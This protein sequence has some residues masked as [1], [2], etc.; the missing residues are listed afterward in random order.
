MD[1]FKLVGTASGGASVPPCRT[2]A[3]GAGDAV[4]S[5]P[6]DY[7]RSRTSWLVSRNGGEVKL[8]QN[9]HNSSSTPSLCLGGVG[10]TSEKT[11]V[12]V[13][14]GSPTALVFRVTTG[15]ISPQ[16]DNTTCLTAVQ[17]TWSDAAAVK[18]ALS[19]CAA[20]PSETQ[21][22]QYNP[23]TRALRPK[24]SSCIAT[25]FGE[26]TRAQYRDCCIALC[27]TA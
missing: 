13:R 16:D 3:L 17:R 24:A 7:P 5:T 4:V 1:N 25:S 6:C 20:I 23:S 15:Q 2:S 19:V 21:Q 26:S 12:L 10:S 18:M 14:C 11:V 27:P 9:Q 8:D 22:F